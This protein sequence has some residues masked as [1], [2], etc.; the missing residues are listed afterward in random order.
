M[1]L[2]RVFPRKTNATPTDQDVRFTIPLQKDIDIDKV[3]IS[4]TFTYDLK[5]A[6]Y[7]YHHWKYIAPTE[8]GGPAFMQPENEFIPG[9]FL[10]EGITITS[11]GCPNKCWFCS[12]WK[13]NGSLK[14]L[15]I[16]EGFNIMDDNLLACSDQHIDNVFEMLKKQPQKPI[17]SGG[18]D[19]KLLTD[20]IAS[21]LY[22]LKPERLYFANDTQDDIEPLFEAGK[23][24]K[25]A[26]FNTKHHTLMCYVLIG[27]PSDNFDNAKKRIEQT[28]EAGFMPFAML[29]RNQKGKVNTEWRKFQRQ[30]TNPIICASNMTALKK[31]KEGAGKL[32][33]PNGLQT[34]A[35]FDGGFLNIVFGKYK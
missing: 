2:I 10:K 8:M 18:L 28:I 27:Y 23:T 13:R 21:K 9:L 6:E 1:K 16:K 19:S 35:G 11:R 17:F 12:V 3:F 5:N 20:R 7:L 32:T 34:K 4:V 30:W 14:E 24:L 31:Q 15:E 25:K 33:V 26:G 29:Y 22:E